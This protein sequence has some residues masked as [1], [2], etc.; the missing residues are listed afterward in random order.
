MGI[1]KRALGLDI[2]NIGLTSDLDHVMERGEWGDILWRSDP[3]PG[4]FLADPVGV[5]ND[6]DGTT[7]LLI[8]ELPHWTNRGRIVSVSLN[9]AFQTAPVRVEID[10][11]LHLSY[12][13]TVSLENETHLF[14][15]CGTSGRLRHYTLEQ[16]K[17]AEKSR[18]F[19]EEPII[20][21][22][23]W[24]QD[25]IWYLFYTRADTDPN[26]RLFLKTAPHLE[27]PWTLHPAFPIFIGT[28]GARPAGPLFT[29][30]GRLFRPSQDCSVSYGGGVIIHEIEQLSPTEWRET[31]FRRLDQPAG[32]YDV[33]LHTFFA[34]DNRLIIDA[35]RVSY[36]VLA[37]IIK[38][39]NL[40]RQFAK[41]AF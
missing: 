34:F 36:G 19:L 1:M 24:H 31:I 7:R 39:R 21:P 11:P 3:G 8:E 29:W 6:E 30:R 27:G 18:N 14:P 33:G 25:G 41:K 26:A 5:F 35:K 28:A 20:D 23:F 37:P 40:I 4:R 16:G 2:W 12:P 10:D 9:S 22:T 13:F 17:W 15:E 32:V 38:S